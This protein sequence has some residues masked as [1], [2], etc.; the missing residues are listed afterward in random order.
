MQRVTGLAWREGQMKLKRYRTGLLAFHEE[1]EQPAPPYKGAGWHAT[2]SLPQD[3]PVHQSRE[4]I[5]HASSWP[6]AQRALNLI[7]ACIYLFGGSPPVFDREQQLIAH[8]NSEPQFDDP[9][10][11]QVYAGGRLS[12]ANIPIACALAAKASMRKKYE[13]AVT[14]YNFSINQHSQQGVDLE[15]FSSPHLGVS[16]FPDDHVTFCHA[17]LSAYSVLEEIGLELR[18]SRDR[19]SRINGG[20]N[21]VVRL[22]IE[23]RLQKAGI[24]TDE[25]ILWT[26]RGPR[27]KLERRRGIPVLRKCPWSR[28]AVR[29]CDLEI[30]DAIAYA[31]WIRDCVAAHNAKDLTKV[32]T[33]YDVVNVQHL[34][35]RLLL[36]ALGFWRWFKVQKRRIPNKESSARG[37]PRR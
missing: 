19:P 29:D 25:P 23:T 9:D 2:L 13:Y 26:V 7:S 36:E 11:H 4:V 37:D 34:A 15:P 33:P 35:R 6:S 16:F 8:N 18:A 10:L 24:N 1:R 5:I 12:R 20:W 31:D 22:D 14:K 30:A 32:L 3:R 27:R 28:A 17:I 21:P